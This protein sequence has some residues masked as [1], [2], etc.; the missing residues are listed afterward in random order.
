VAKEL[1]QFMGLPNDDQLINDL[2]ERS[3]FKFY[4]GRDRGQ[5]DRKRFYRKGVAG[6]WK[7]HFTEEDKRA[8]KALAGDML[9]RLGYERDLS[10]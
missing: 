7:N 3:S 5:E 2:I 8:F 1:F 10:W 4:A 6:D 9:I